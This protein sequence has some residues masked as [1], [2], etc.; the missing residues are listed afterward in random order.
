MVIYVCLGVYQPDF[1]GY[2][3]A[4]EAKVE[5]T[6]VNAANFMMITTTDSHVTGS[7]FLHWTRLGERHKSTRR[8]EPIHPKPLH[9][10]QNLQLPI[11]PSNLLHLRQITLQILLTRINL[12]SPLVS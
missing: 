7:L 4:T 9:L 5:L 11:P 2:Y 6:K 12:K 3:F 10:I 1:L 8:C